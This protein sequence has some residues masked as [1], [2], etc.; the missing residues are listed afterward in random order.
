MYVCGLEEE[1]DRD[2]WRLIIC[3]SEKHN[4]LN[5]ESA[6]VSYVTCDHLLFEDD[7]VKFD[8]Q[9]VLV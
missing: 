1:T 8:L 4:R 6:H 7:L 9:I 2:L 5:N 3:I